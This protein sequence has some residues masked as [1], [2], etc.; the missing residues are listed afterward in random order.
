M[1]GQHQSLRQRGL[2]RVVGYARLLNAWRSRIPK[3]QPRAAGV[4]ALIAAIILGHRHEVPRASFQ[5]D[6]AEVFDAATPGGRDSRAKRM[7]REMAAAGLVELTGNR[8]RRGG[9][10]GLAD[11]GRGALETLG[12]EFPG[13]TIRAVL[14]VGAIWSEGVKAYL[15]SEGEARLAVEI[16]A[17]ALR[18]AGRQRGTSWQAYEAAKGTEVRRQLVSDCSLLLIS[19]RSVPDASLPDASRAELARAIGLGADARRHYDRA[20]R[21]AG[22]LDSDQDAVLAPGYRILERIGQE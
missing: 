13:T 11:A 10:I 21:W 15:S 5:R 3:E 16:R 1:D 9:T 2:D 18:A 8:G 7:I 12:G 14:Q 22:F 6:I 4:E 20:L 17:W 19:E